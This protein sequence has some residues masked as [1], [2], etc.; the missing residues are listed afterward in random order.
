MTTFIKH[1]RI[2]VKELK[3]EPT[4]LPAPIIIPHRPVKRFADAS[5]CMCPT[6]VMKMALQYDNSRPVMHTAVHK[7][8]HICLTIHKT[9]PYISML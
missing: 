3:Y 8:H 4:I 6:D 2:L 5:S 1:T 7:L 9:V